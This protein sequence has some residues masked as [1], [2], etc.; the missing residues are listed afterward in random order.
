MRGDGTV[1]GAEAPGVAGGLDVLHVPFPLPCGRV[2]VLGPVVHV[3][4]LPM[5]DAGQHLPLGGPVAGQLVGDE[6]L[7][8]IL[9]PLEGMC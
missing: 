5:L 1:G 2:R 8:D 4:V 3:P 9:E 6:D 7:R